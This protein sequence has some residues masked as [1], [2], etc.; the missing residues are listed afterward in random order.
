VG[1]TD[2]PVSFNFAN[3]AVKKSIAACCS[4]VFWLGALARAVVSTSI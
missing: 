4:T 2:T 1:V 3:S